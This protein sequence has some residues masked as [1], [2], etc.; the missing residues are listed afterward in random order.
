MDA[1]AAAGVHRHTAAEVFDAGAQVSSE[2][3]RYAKVI[4]S[5]DLQHERLRA[6]PEPRIGAPPRSYMDKPRYPGAP[7]GAHA[8]GSAERVR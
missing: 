5:T 2:Q 7:Y 3:R 8:H 4:A 1:F 6:R